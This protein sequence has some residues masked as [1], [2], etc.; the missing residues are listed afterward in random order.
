MLINRRIL[1]FVGSVA[2][3]L[4]VSQLVQAVSAA[5]KRPN[6]LFIIVDD[7]SPFDL[8]IYNPDSGLD[9]PN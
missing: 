5:D 1:R 4:L 7:Q 8:K 2:L 9:T 3:L 6:I